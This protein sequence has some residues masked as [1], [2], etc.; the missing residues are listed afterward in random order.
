MK[1]LTTVSG[2]EPRSTDKITHVI[3]HYQME[4]L[5]YIQ[6]QIQRFFLLP[7]ETNE[8]FY[9]FKWPASRLNAKDTVTDG[10]Q[11]K[12]CKWSKC[13]ANSGLSI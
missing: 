2:F 1:I 3:N 4:R 6:D 7:W 13:V 12:A 9:N 10:L 5:E 8:T 11:S